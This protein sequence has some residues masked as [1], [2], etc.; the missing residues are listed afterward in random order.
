MDDLHAIR[1]MHCGTILLHFNPTTK[2]LSNQYE[3]I[4]KSLIDFFAADSSVVY[5]TDDSSKQS[6]NFLNL[7]KYLS[8]KNPLI[9]LSDLS[10]QR[11]V[12]I[13]F[14]GKLHELFMLPGVVVLWFCEWTCFYEPLKLVALAQN[15]IYLRVGDKSAVTLMDDYFIL[16][17][18]PMNANDLTYEEYCH[19]MTKTAIVS[20][21]LRDHI[22]SSYCISTLCFASSAIED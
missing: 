12:D 16:L 11:V 3:L 18:N 2:A 19:G 9:V 17:W 1:Q 10:H 13:D 21:N 8:V 20:Y 7:H 14:L 4:K 5:I 15:T 22:V 6:S